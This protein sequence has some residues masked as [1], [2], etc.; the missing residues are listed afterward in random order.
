MGKV[1]IKK[2]TKQELKDMCDEYG[3]AKSGNK[4]ALEKRLR[5]YLKAHPEEEDDEVSDDQED[6][7]DNIKPDDSASNH[8][9]TA[10][11]VHS[12][13]AL[14]IARLKGLQAQKEA[15]GIPGFFSFRFGFE[16]VVF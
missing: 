15:L 2:L 6:L 14:N 4:S 8:G 5:E 16:A 7:Q 3:L 9:S 11:S 1:N 13:R 12:K 10:S